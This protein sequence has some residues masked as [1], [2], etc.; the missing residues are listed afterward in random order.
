LNRVLR[1]PQISD[2]NPN[3]TSLQP[4]PHTKTLASAPK[5]PNILTPSPATITRHHATPAASHPTTEIP[6]ELACFHPYCPCRS[7]DLA[8]DC[9]RARDVVRL[10]GETL[11]LGLPGLRLLLLLRAR[12]YPLSFPDML[13]RCFGGRPR[14]RTYASAVP[15]VGPSSGLAKR[16]RFFTEASCLTVSSQPEAF[17]SSLVARSC[18]SSAPSSS[19]FSQGINVQRNIVLGSA[20]ASAVHKPIMT[21]ERTTSQAMALGRP[22]SASKPKFARAVYLI[23]LAISSPACCV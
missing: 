8:R 6:T 15:V 1:S 4:L 19:S 2:S 3:N 9:E 18:H 7:C 11:F 22:V 16:V 17:V 21:A 13:L 12:A 5:A 20:S 10:L 23:S 14:L